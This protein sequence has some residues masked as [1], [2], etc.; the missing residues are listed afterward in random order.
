MCQ[1][2]DDRHGWDKK[3]A[4]EGDLRQKMESRGGVGDR[5]SFLLCSLV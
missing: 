4:D 5:F 2:A 3:V 1:A